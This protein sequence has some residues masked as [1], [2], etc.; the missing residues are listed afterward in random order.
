MKQTVGLLLTLSYQ[1]FYKID[2][3]AASFFRISRLSCYITVCQGAQGK[4]FRNN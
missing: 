2:V 1:T 3:A 4:G